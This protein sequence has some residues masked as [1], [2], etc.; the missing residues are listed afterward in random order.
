MS[1]ALHCRSGVKNGI[2]CGVT[3]SS[4]SANL[5]HLCHS[6]GN[7]V[8]NLLNNG[9]AVSAATAADASSQKRFALCC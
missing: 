6:L 1:L 9:G 2:R 3:L 7:A 5:L 4:V 8:L